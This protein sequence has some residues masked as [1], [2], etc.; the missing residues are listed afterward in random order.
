MGL[1]VLRFVSFWRAQPHLADACV[2]ARKRKR[3][4]LCVAFVAAE[5][6]HPPTQARLQ[7]DTCGGIA[8]NKMMCKIA[9]NMHKPNGVCCL[10]FFARASCW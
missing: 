4:H 8:A 3:V 5:R 10:R 1:C 6:G 2:C 9:V 7:F